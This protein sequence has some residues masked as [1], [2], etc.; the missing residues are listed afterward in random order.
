MVNVIQSNDINAYDSAQVK[1]AIANGAILKGQPVGLYIGTD[2]LDHALLCALDVNSVRYGIALADV[3]S[4]A[5]GKFVVKGKVKVI[6]GGT[7]GQLVTAIG[8]GGGITDAAV[9]NTNADTN[10]LGMSTDTDELILY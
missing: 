9:A 2:G 6:S 3:A 7:S 5:T 4:G 10:V 8:T 1:P